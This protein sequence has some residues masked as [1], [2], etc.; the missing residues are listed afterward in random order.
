MFV[1]FNRRRFV[2]SALALFVFAGGSAASSDAA[3]FAGQR[4]GKNRNGEEVKVVREV[5]SRAGYEDR[6]QAIAVARMAGAEPAVVVKGRDARWHA[7]ETT[8]NAAAGLASAADNIDIRELVPLPSSRGLS[9]VGKTNEAPKAYLARALGLEAREVE[10][11]ASSSSRDARF[12]NINAKLVPRGLHGPEKTANEPFAPEKKT[13]IELNRSLFERGDPR[14]A[15]SVLFHEVVHRLDYELTQRWATAYT[16]ETGRI[17]M[18]GPLFVKWLFERNP[19]VLPRDDAQTVADVAAGA[20]GST[21]ARAYVGTFIAAMQ[22]GAY[23]VAREELVTYARGLGRSIDLPGEDIV[24]AALRRDLETAYRALDTNG[25]KQFDAA[26]T[27][28]RKA[29]PETWI[30]KARR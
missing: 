10:P 28:V 21:E 23:E 26:F 24:P 17:F 7:L 16:R 22:A 9:G 2:A 8:A 30:A 3:A 20:N 15:S 25:K 29:A 13:A 6:L 1:S 12:I 14:E 18:P 5:G 19:R 27:A 11:T 4:L